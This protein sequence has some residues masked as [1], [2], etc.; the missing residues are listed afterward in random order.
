MML[1]VGWAK[2]FITLLHL[3][4]I[5]S[6][7]LK[8]GKRE[9]FQNRMYVEANVEIV[10]PGLNISQGGRGE[11]TTRGYKSVIQGTNIT[12]SLENFKFQ[13]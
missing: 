10:C 7:R 12:S 2:G 11:V 1:T 9:R 13:F 8:G 4:N 3:L 5:D 6:T